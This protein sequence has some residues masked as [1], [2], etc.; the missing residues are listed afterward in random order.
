MRS[1]VVLSDRKRRILKA[2]VDDFTQSSLPVSSKDIQIK[3]CIDCSSAT[4][5]NELSTLES[6]GYLV[7]LHTSS[8]RI[9]SDKAFK[10]YVEELMIRKPL[11]RKDNDFIAKAFE[12]RL[13]SI[14]E[15]V[16]TVANVLCELTNYTSVVV[17]LSSDNEIIERISIVNVGGLNALVIVVTNNNIYKD[18]LI[19]LTAFIDDGMLSGAC[20]WLNR[21]F[22]G[23]T[24]NQF[25]DPTV[26]LKAVFNEF[27]LFNML[28]LKVVEVLRKVSNI[29]DTDVFVKGLNLIFDYY[30]YNDVAKLRQF[31]TKLEDKMLLS[32]LFNSGSN[33]INLLF[34]DDTIVQMPHD[35]AIVSAKISLRNKTLGTAGVIGP[36]QMDYNKVISILEQINKFTSK[37]LSSE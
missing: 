21:L 29:K 3:Y 36:M 8:G 26:P 13:N 22:A 33:P 19:Q 16:S 2:V 37:L 34:G 24:L 14:E 20:S 31:I 30:A 18:N 23:A 11:S 1:E 5:R 10:F 6:M 15:I 17:K 27:Q 12:H 9:P 28:Y 35:C 25:A 7:Q 32:Q 4:I